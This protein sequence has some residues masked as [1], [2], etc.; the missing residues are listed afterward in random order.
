M[1]DVE[2]ECVYCGNKWQ[3]DPLQWKDRSII[4]AEKLLVPNYKEL[5]KDRGEPVPPSN[6]MWISCPKCNGTNVFDVNEI[7]EMIIGTK[8][9]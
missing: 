9:R 6:M 4:K 5:A 8:V 7:K 3:V 2:L 1:T